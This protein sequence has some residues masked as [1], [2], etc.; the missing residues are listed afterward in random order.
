MSADLIQ[1]SRTLRTQW[2]ALVEWIDQADLDDDVLAEESAVTGWSVGELVSHLGR[3][4]DALA[5]CGPVPPGTVPLSLA[6]YLGTYPQRS[7]EITTVTRE[8]DAEIRRDRVAGISAKA[9]RAFATLDD[10]GPHD[11]VVQARRGPIMLRDMVASR[12]IELVVHGDDLE[13]SLPGIAG[14]PLERDAL[15]LAADELL[16]IVVARGGWSLEV[17]DARTWIRLAAGRVPYDVDDLTRALRP[18]FTAGG[19]PDLG[20]VLPVV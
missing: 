16:R 14:S 15:A 6:E 5:V 13:R 11:L 12:L 4:M 9:D 7:A 20:R 8:L 1:L 3:A 18:E 19:V 17:A 2:D 10:L